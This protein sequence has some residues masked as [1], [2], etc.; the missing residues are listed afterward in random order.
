M[1]LTGIGVD[2]CRFHP[3]ETFPVDRE[4]NTMTSIN[5]TLLQLFS[6][7]TNHALGSDTASLW[8]T[9]SLK[10]SAL[11]DDDDESCMSL[12]S[13]DLDVTLSAMVEVFY[14]TVH[15][16]KLGVRFFSFFF[17]FTPLY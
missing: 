2:Y 10:G 5:S 8:F 4:L 16:R 14:V 1:N 3:T 12:G 11:V 6:A 13:S 7:W 9:A 15:F 17:S